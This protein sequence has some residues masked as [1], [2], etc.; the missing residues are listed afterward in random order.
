MTL[1]LGRYAADDAAPSQGGVAIDGSEGASVQLATCCRPIPG[2]AIVGYLGRGEGL[3]VHTA[4]CH[5]GK[6]LKERDPERWMAVEWAEQPVRPFETMVSVQVRNG[7]G[8]LAQVAASVSAAVSRSG[9]SQAS[10]FTNGDSPSAA[11]DA[12]AAGGVDAGGTGAASAA[13]VFPLRNENSPM[14]TP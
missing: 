4:D 13:S 11:T 6:R 3:L 9:A 5:N 2:D 14:T 1:T 8:A 10:G 12:A 7:K